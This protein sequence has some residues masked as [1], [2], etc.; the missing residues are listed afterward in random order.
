MEG[1]RVAEAC[2]LWNSRSASSSPW[3]CSAAADRDRASVVCGS[4][5]LQG[6][7]HGTDHSYSWVRITADGPNGQKEW[8]G[9]NF[10]RGNNLAFMDPYLAVWPERN[11]P[12]AVNLDLYLDLIRSTLT[13]V[14]NY[15]TKSDRANMTL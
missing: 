13:D 15:A 14:R 3:P 2:T 7:S 4:E 8:A 12:S 5:R 1:C 11:A 6:A 10:R 9:E